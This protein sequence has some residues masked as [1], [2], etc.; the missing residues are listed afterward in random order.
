MKMPEQ[1]EEESSFE[2]TPMIDMV[3]LLLVFFMI[4]SRMSTLQ[5]IDLEIP[6][7]TEAVVPTDRPQRFVININA[8][9]EMFAGAD[10]LG[11]SDD[12][13]AQAALR[14]LAQEQK[15]LAPEIRVYVR[16]DQMSDHVH[17]SRVMNV[18]AEEGFDD[19]IFGAFQ[20]GGGS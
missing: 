18:M 11:P 5:N 6:T 14:E 12:S 19:F 10:L 15:A 16:A 17:V 20:P 8:N 1:T 7:A 9:G 3:F 2:M 4:A 13:G